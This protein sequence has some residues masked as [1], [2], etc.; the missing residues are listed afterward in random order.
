MFNQTITNLKYHDYEWGL[1]GPY[2][3]DKRY[4]WGRPDWTGQS[5]YLASPFE[6][7]DFLNLFC[8]ELG[9]ETSE[10]TRIYSKYKNWI[11]GYVVPN[12]VIN[13]EYQSDN[14][15]TIFWDYTQHDTDSAR[16]YCAN[17]F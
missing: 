9:F 1:L 6:P 5:V 15:A 12:H 10:Y 7:F 14:L 2:K 3:I 13:L 4:L 11:L 17:S 8:F 16:Y